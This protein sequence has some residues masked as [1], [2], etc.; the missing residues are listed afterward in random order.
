MTRPNPDQ[1]DNSPNETPAPD[2]S[3]SITDQVVIAPETGAGTHLDGQDDIIA[4]LSA[5]TPADM[6]MELMLDHLTASNDLF[7]SPHL[8]LSALATSLGDDHG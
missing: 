8:D 4:A 3:I 6:N 7:S 2:T 5:T 1:A